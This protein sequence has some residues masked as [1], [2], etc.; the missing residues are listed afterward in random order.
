MMSGNFINCFNYEENTV[1]TEIMKFKL[2]DLECKHIINTTENPIYNASVH[3]GYQYVVFGSHR[4][5]TL[6][7]ENHIINQM[8]NDKCFYRPIRVVLAKDNKLW[9]DN[10][11]SAIAYLR[12]YGMEISLCDIP[13]YLVDVSR[14]TPIIVSIDQTVIPNIEAIKKSI[15]C[16]LRINERLDLGVRP[17]AMKWTIEDL[18][19]DIELLFN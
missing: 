11:H 15:D 10:T 5:G 16:A 7:S 9:C 1:K 18:K 8:A 2:K 13:F 17:G 12:R 4:N 6:E 3:A 19:K 14:N